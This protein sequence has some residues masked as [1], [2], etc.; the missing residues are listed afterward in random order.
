MQTRG[1][2]KRTTKMLLQNIISLQ[3]TVPTMCSSSYQWY[4]RKTISLR[5]LIW[6]KEES[7]EMRD[8]VSRLT[9]CYRKLEK[10]HLSLHLRRSFQQELYHLMKL[11]LTCVMLKKK[12]K[13]ISI[14]EVF[15]W[16]TG[17]KINLFFPPS[18]IWSWNHL[19][20]KV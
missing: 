12:E 16:N 15:Y 18:P 11:L 14:P 10:I 13:R 3:M 1:G 8:M 2:T 7:H 20:K 19:R 6:Q 5:I 4:K 17:G 9:I